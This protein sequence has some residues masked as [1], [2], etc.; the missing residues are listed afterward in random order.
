MTPKE[1]LHKAV[2]IVGS[3]SRLAR[4]IGNGVTQAH[5]YYWLTRAQVVPAEYCPTIEYIVK[6]EVKCEELN[7]RVHWWVLRNGPPATLSWGRT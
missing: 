1:A 5:V 2:R 6:R 4:E 7:P 3:Q